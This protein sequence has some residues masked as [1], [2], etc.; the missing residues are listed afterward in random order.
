MND[1]FDLYK[2]NFETIAHDIVQQ[3]AYEDID[4]VAMICANYGVNLYDMCRSEQAELQ[5]QVMNLVQ[6]GW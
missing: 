1:V 6:Q 5:Q 2:M 3:E 4:H